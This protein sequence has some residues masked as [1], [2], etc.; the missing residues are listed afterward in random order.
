M[1]GIILAAGQGVRLRPLTDDRPKCMVPYL[2]RPLI[3]HILEVFGRCSISPIVVVT[4]YCSNIL[5]QHARRR[6]LRFVHNYDFATTNMV[7]SLFCAENEM[8][9]DLIVTYSDIVY[10]PE[11]L[12]RLLES[13]ADLAITIDTQ[14]LTL[15]KQ[16]MDDPL[17]DAETMQISAN[18]HVI[19][20]GRK[21][22][23]YDEIQGQ[24]MGLIKISGRIVRRV[25][26]LFHA[27]DPAAIYDGKPLRQMFMT[28]FIRMMIQDG[29]PCQAV[30]VEG[31]WLE[32]D[33]PAD[34]TLRH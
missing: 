33:T 27:L 18:G 10:R 13:T 16:R 29:I 12:K 22:R 3:D 8:N 11:V 34:L 2:G 31:G 30:P 15:W 14:W 26:S 1:K 32:V 23:S 20:L 21:P 6:S 28:T 7:H 24:Y 4:G 25:R 9:D 17:E 19:D 5:E